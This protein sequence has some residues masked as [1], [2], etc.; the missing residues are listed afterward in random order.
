MISTLRDKILFPISLL[1]IFFFATQAL[2]QLS[3]EAEAGKAVFNKNCKSCHLPD[4]DLTGPALVG[5]WD[6]IPGDDDEA[7]KE[8]FVAWVHNSGAVINSG[9]EYAVNLFEEWKAQ[10][11]PMPGLS[12]EE[13]MSVKTYIDEYKPETTNGDSGPSYCE[14][15]QAAEMAN[16]EPE[17]GNTNIFIIGA[18]VIVL[19]I[20]VNALVG[21]RR[22][23][24][25][26]INE[27]EGKPEVE[28]KGFL[29]A[30]K[31]WV[32][33]H[34]LQ[35]GF[36][37]IILISA[38]AVDGW[39][40]LWDIGVY[41]GY[42]KEGEDKKDYRPVQPIKFSHKIHA[43]EYE[44]DCQYCHSGASKGKSAV[45][46]SLNV[47][48]NCHKGISEGSC[49][50]EEEIGKIYE[51]VGWNPDTRS[52]DKPP[53]AVKWVRIHN[54]PDFAYFNHSQHVVAGGQ[55]CQTCHGP[56]EE[57][58]IVQQYSP[59]TMGWCI[60]CHIETDVDMGSV[61]AKDEDGNVL[62][63][64]DGV[65]DSLV[66]QGNP[67]YEKMYNQLVESHKD[68]NLKDFQVKNIGGLECGKCHY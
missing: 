20:L 25:N 41:G 39:N 27:S 31:E 1:A 23:I 51:A 46:P 3:P 61:V 68:K 66:Y 58:H 50:G 57:M 33:G 14:E 34:K 22:N 24:Q 40:R 32:M 19:L 60:D 36:L 11:T 28:A 30:T 56:I 9:D 55:E 29:T 35:V 63:S 10:M 21:I 38:G 6:R 7:K 37:L 12:E 18:L 52:Y 8:W 53:K 43:G 2:G 15:Y 17:S 5:F 62:K 48:M 59:L 16:K 26:T 49:Y 64:K 65:N 45:I 42:E 44:I 54:L 67:Y 47:C 13:I 4:K